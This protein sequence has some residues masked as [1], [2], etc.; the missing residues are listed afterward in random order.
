M[1]PPS[2]PRPPPP[3]M[4]E[5]MEEVLL[6]LPPD[7]PASLVCKRWCRL[8]SD[9]SF[10]RRLLDF[11]RQRQA[12]PP[13]LG[14]LI[15]SDDLTYRD[16]GARFVPTTVACPMPATADCGRLKLPNPPSPATG[17]SH[18]YNRT[19]AVLC[20]A[21]ATATG[22]CSHLDCH[23]R[24]SFI[25]VLVGD[26]TLCE[27]FISIWWRHSTLVGNALYFVL[28]GYKSILEYNLCTRRTSVIKLPGEGKNKIPESFGPIQLITT[29]E[30]G[31]RL[32]FVR[33]EDFSRLCIWS[34]EDEEP[35]GWVLSNVIE[36]DKLLP[37][38]DRMPTSWNYLV[39]SAEGVGTIFLKLK[40]EL[41]TADL[42]SGL[43]TKV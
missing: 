31:R 10:Q 18:L 32:G 27:K 38:D 40:D 11:H 36:L 9:P 42:R 19:A 13:M 21:T 37:L 14:F 41:F 3:L 30:D 12:A 2:P 34:R 43:V 26:T 20:A 35:A 1:P 33:V 8:V 29:M 28:E 5:L 23:R 25:V 39:G 24:G 4:D 22:A 7:S 17:G 15:F 6:R 16:I